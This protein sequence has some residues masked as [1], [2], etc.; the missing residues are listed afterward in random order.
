MLILL[1][2]LVE[3]IMRV[4]VILAFGGTIYEAVVAEGSFGPSTSLATT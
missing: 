1:L 2:H 4:E 3:A